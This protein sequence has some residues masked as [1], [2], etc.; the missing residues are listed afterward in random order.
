MKSYDTLRRNVT[1]FQLHDT[2]A[3]DILPLLCLQHV[4]PTIPYSFAILRHRSSHSSYVSSCV[5]I[6]MQVQHIIVNTFGHPLLVEKFSWYP[7]YTMI[8]PPL[9]YGVDKVRVLP[10]IAIRYTYYVVTTLKEDIV[11]T[12]PFIKGTRYYNSMY[13]TT[14]S[15]APL[16]PKLY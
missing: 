7:V 5:S 10:S 4:H 11:Y 16:S 6:N 15:T 9:G 2:G 14:I 8:T 12:V 1:S 13:S 3:F